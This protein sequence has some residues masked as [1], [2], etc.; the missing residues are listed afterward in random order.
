MALVVS[1]LKLCGWE[2]NVIS[3]FLIFNKI[4]CCFVVVVALTL[5]YRL[6][7]LRVHFFHIFFLC[8]FGIAFITT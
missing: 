4:C 5:L 1:G 2:S 7:L 3:Y 8:S 6:L